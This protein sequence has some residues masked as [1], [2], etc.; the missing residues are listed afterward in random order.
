MHITRLNHDDNIDFIP[1]LKT[2]SIHYVSVAVP[3]LTM[4]C[5]YIKSAGGF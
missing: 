1:L 4:V 5:D 2:G 3:G